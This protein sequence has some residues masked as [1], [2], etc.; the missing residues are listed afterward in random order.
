[1]RLQRAKLHPPE[2]VIQSQIVGTLRSMGH[3][4]LSTVHRV[5]LVRCP[6]CSQ[7]FRPPGSYGADKGVPDLIVRPGPRAKQQWP[8]GVFA[9]LEVKGAKTPLSPEQR[10][11]QQQGAIVIVRSVDEAIEAYQDINDELE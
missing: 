10:V 1:M 4:V 11:L 3:L 7:Q 9:G 5:K 6:H 8:D 2:E